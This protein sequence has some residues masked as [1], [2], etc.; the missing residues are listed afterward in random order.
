MTMTERAKLGA[1]VANARWIEPR[2]Q[3]LALLEQGECIKRA[4][5]KA[6][7]AVRTARRYRQRQERG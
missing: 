7:V 5:H 6:G 1:A 3:V 4:A 2:A